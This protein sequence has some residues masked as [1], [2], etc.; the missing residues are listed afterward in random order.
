M[1]TCGLCGTSFQFGTGVYDGKH[2]ARYQL[3]VCRGCWE[4]NHDG[5]A[6][7]LETKLVAHLNAKGIQIP[8]R[9]AA[10]WYPRE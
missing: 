8:E 4:G 9:N 2:I 1:Q 7:W 10:G 3:T 6:K 5:W